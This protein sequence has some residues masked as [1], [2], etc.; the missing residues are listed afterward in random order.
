MGKFQ[1]IM[2]TCIEDQVVQAITVFPCQTV[3]FSIKYPGLP[4]SVSKLPKSVLQP[5]IDKIVDWPLAWKG[6][7][8]HHS[9]YL[10]LIKTTLATTPVYLVISF[11]FPLV[12]QSD[13]KDLQSIPVDRH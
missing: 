13:D 8:M 2:I 9:G 1:I 4:L 6:C 10:T 3:S 11:H 5:L 12:P 7:L